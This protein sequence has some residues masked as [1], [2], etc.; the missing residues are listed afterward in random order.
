[1]KRK[2]TS[3]RKTLDVVSMFA[4]CGGLDLGFT[5]GFVYKDTLY[6]KHPFQVI[7]AF[8]IDPKA[9]ETY[10]RNIGLEIEQADLSCIDPAD[11]PSADLLIGGFP[12]QEFS[13]CGPQGGL[14]T[15]RGRLYQALVKYMDRHCPFVVVAENVI[16]L[17]RMQSGVV[18]RTIMS[19]LES[20]GPGYRF[21]V[22][23]LFA[24]DYGVP[25]C[26][27]RLFIVG[28]RNDL[29]GQPEAPDARF[30]D[31]HRSIDWAIEDL[32]GISDES[33]PNQS[34]YFLASRARKGNGQGDETNRIGEPSYC[35]RANPKSR[36]QFH[37]KLDRRL[38][39][40]ECARLQTF[41]DNFEFFH[42]TTANISQIGNAV[43]PILGHAVA[44]SVSSYLSRNVVKE[45]LEKVHPTKK[46]H[47]LLK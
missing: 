32:E 31:S 10:R 40:R 4:G 37:Y 9:V 21:Q 20:A 38:T 14:S 3:K 5:G 44:K 25:Q 23:R 18:L 15:E 30:A 43:P 17:E 12:C 28:V 33:V 2:A 26:R 45:H 42:S 19:D 6:S 35:I 22:W 36:V 39:V 47:L 46:N 11:I 24:P 8:D 16:N 34:Q 13:S 27:H 41:P 1:M 7:K 29:P